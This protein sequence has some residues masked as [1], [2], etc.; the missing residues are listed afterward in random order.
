MRLESPKKRHDM[1][2][3]R[4]R[5]GLITK[6]HAATLNESCRVALLLSPGEASDCAQFE[7]LYAELPQ[8]NVLQSAALDKGYD[9]NRTREILTLDGIEPVIPGRSNRR[10]VIIYDRVK[11]AKRNV[12]ERFFNKLKQFRCIAT[13]LE[14]YAHTF[15]AMTH[16]VAAFILA[17]N[18]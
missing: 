3:G 18:S 8:E 15:L 1:A 14:K 7:A 16:I 4:P 11:Y 5:V 9:A 12:V 10:E 13:R 2:L 6:I 17:R